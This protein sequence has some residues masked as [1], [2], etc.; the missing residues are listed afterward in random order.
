MELTI[1]AELRDELPPLDSIELDHLTKSIE[2]DGVLD[3]IKFWWNDD[4]Q[5]N[6]IVDGHHR[7]EIAERL[8]KEFET[9]ELV[10]ESITAVKLWQNQTQTGRRKHRALERMVE[11]ET[12]LRLERDGVKPKV[13]EVVEA[14]AD[15]ANVHPATVYRHVAKAKMGYENKF[16]RTNA[17]NGDSIDKSFVFN[18]ADFDDFDQT[19]P[20]EG[21]IEDVTNDEFNQGEP[22]DEQRGAI[23]AAQP[24]RAKRP[25]SIDSQ[26]R[27]AIKGYELALNK[28]QGLSV[29]LPVSVLLPDFKAIFA[30]IE[31]AKSEMKPAKKKFGR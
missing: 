3:S 19:L 2:R 11:L 25:T 6:E 28:I 15:A 14:V 20:S 31:K 7:F 1:N 26:L 24:K 10:F 30:S 13:S 17:S 27:N 12:Q 21:F 29:H 16:T 5:A 8:G 22:T 23:R 9:R 18:N 4:T